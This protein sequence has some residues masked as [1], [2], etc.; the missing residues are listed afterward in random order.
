M[1]AILAY[2]DSITYGVNPVI[3]GA[4]HAYEDRWPGGSK[5]G[6]PARRA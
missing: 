5:R 3:G 4:R 2:G 1:K 6:S